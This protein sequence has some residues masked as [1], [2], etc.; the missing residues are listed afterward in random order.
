[1]PLSY[2]ITTRLQYQ[3]ETMHELVK[4]FSEEKL[5]LTVNP[6]KWSVFENMVHL[7]SYQPVFLQRIQLIEQKE[8]PSFERYVAENDP[9]FGDSLKLSV[10][11]LLENTST[12]RFLI[13]K[14]IIQLGETTL[15]RTGIHPKFGCLSISQWTDFFLLHEAHHLFTIFMLTAE[16]RKMLQQ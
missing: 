12:Q 13:H 6:G 8:N 5:K 4:G 3:H 7:T 2:S 10:K 16:L 1:M 15:R 9:V 14:H 11:E